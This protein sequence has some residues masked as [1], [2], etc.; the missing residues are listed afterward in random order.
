MDS[1][2]AALANLSLQDKPNISATADKH[3]VKRSTLSRRWNKVTRSREDG[4]NLMRFLSTIQS[5]AL[6][7]YINDL[8]ERGLP[9]IVQMVQNLAAGIARRQPG[10]HW[11]A[12]WLAAHKNELKLGYL[13]PINIARKK[14]DSALYYSLYFKLLSRK[15]AKYNIL[16]ENIYNMDEKGLLIGFLIKLQRVFSKKAFNDGRIKNISQDGNREWITIIAAICADGT[17]LS[18]GLIY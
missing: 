8:T 16:P 11:T 14:A 9:P 10:N 2:E 12:R 3:K 1:I 17:S 18:L 5:K 13:P 7:K 15:I 4:Y 6:I